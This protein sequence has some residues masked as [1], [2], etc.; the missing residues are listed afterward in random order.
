MSECS[1]SDGEST[2]NMSNVRLKVAKRK[3]NRKLLSSESYT[4]TRR[5]ER[6]SSIKEEPVTS[7]SEEYV[8]A[9]GFYPGEGEILAARGELFLGELLQAVKKS[10]AKRGLEPEKRRHSTCNI[11]VDSKKQPS[12]IQCGRS[13]PHLSSEI[14]QKKETIN[15]RELASTFDDA[16]IARNQAAFYRR[17]SSGFLSHIDSLEFGISQQQG[18]LIRSRE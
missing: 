14:L 12:S 5:N 4:I 18:V 3:I 13:N 9:E 8:E 17:E 16:Q 1:S 11:T 10:R 6:L 15:S 7:G 2:F